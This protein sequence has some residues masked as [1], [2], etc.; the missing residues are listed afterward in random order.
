M[1]G[2]CRI[3][4]ASNDRW[5]SHKIA[6]IGLPI[7]ANTVLMATDV[8]EGFTTE[9]ERGNDSY[10]TLEPDTREEAERPR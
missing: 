8:V 3:G 5:V 6:N 9:L 4:D 10:I 7:G 2:R 1:E